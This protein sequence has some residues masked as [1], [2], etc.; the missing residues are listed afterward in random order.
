MN[1]IRWAAIQP[2]TGGAY[3]GTEEAI[4]HPAEWIMS[5]RGFDDCRLDKDGN[6]KSASNEY[7]LRQ[8]LKKHNK[9][10]PYY[11][12]QAE[13]FKINIDFT[14]PNIILDN[15]GCE[16]PDYNDLDLVIAVPVCSGLSMVTSAG[17][18]TKNE[19]N[20]NMQWITN[21]TLK[22]IKPKIYVFENAPTLMGTRGNDLRS[23][24]NK[25]A[26]KYGYSLLYYKTDTCLHDNCQKRPRTFGVFI[27]HNADVEIQNPPLFDFES[28]NV[29]IEEFI[30]RIPKDSTQQTPIKT[31]V[32]NKYIIDYLEYKL[33]SDW[34]TKVNGKLINYVFK[35]NLMDDL[36]KFVE[37]SNKYDKESKERTL[38]YFEHI[39]NKLSKGLNYYGD[40]IQYV[41]DVLPSVQFRSMPNMLHITEDR[42]YNIR[43]YLSLMG[44]PYDFELYGTNPNINQIGQN[45]PV[46]TMKFIA[47]QAY[48]ILEHWND[49]RETIS[50]SVFQNNINKTIKNEES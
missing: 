34:K 4:G 3:L 16:L 43:E 19:R 15:G 36:I 38:H 42:T 18:N 17:E 26:L 49:P 2:L 37:N 13:P 14:K 5:F 22:V 11:R 7:H 50:N 23:W 46:G 29:S 6:I 35:H 48:K 12:I 32:H 44:M 28:N 33:G 41:T 1:K 21:Y 45:V 20:N 10:I 24:F 47:S 31:A 9:D 8:Y 39:D 30:N 27:K 40:D 25:V